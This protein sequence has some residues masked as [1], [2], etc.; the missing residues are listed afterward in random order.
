MGVEEGVGGSERDLATASVLDQAPRT[1]EEEPGS[2]G[3]P[4][5]PKLEAELRTHLARVA[6]LA[7]EAKSEELAAAMRA[8]AVEPGASSGSGD[9]PTA[10][11]APSVPRWRRSASREPRQKKKEEELDLEEAPF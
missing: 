3:G 7:D 9:R 6:E 10:T 1:P 4:L 5:L 8:L 11:R 2:E